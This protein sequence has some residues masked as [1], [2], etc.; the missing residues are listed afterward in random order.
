MAANERASVHYVRSKTVTDLE[1]M[2][3]LAV[4]SVNSHR[5]I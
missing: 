4:I 1:R 5:H 3:D 2:A